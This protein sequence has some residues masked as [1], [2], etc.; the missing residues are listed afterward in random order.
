VIGESCPE[1]VRWVV[2]ELEPKVGAPEV[3]VEEIEP[4][5]LVPPSLEQIQAVRQQAYQVGYE[6][7]LSSGQARGMAQALAQGQAEIRRLTAQIEGIL[8]NFTRPL[9]RLEN[10]VTCA[11]GEL[12][13][14]IA[15]HLVRRA[16]SSDPE[17]L[18][19]LVSQA[20]EAV[21]TTTREVQVYLHPDDLAIFAAQSGNG[22]TIPPALLSLPEGTKFTPDPALSRGDLRVHTESVRIDGSLDARLEQALEQ[23]MQQAESAA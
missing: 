17:L 9:A 20:L 4:E 21:G 22:R 6:E 8:D 13:V 5:Q 12:A 11:L 18:T 2:P 10:E 1:P 3:S 19:A 7:G 23:V 15:G 16:Y 14:K